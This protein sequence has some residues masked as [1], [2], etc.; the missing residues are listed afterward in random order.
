[1][2]VG[3]LIRELSEFIAKIHNVIAVMTVDVMICQN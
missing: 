3:F 2:P 1:M